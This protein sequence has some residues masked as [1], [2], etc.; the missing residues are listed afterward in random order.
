[1][2]GAEANPAMQPAGTVFPQILLPPPTPPP[3][4]KVQAAV[5]FLVGRR[6][7]MICQE[8]GMKETDINAWFIILIFL[9]ETC[10]ELHSLLRLYIELN[11]MQL[12]SCSSHMILL[13][14]FYFS[15]P[16]CCDLIP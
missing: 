3:P 14:F 4:G 16:Y 10:V 13:L 5:Y 12:T 1:M 2:C 8:L 7:E 9:Q 15:V 6:E 11:D